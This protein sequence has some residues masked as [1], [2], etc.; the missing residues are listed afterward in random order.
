MKPRVALLATLDTKAEEAQYVAQRLADF[1]CEPVVFNLGTQDNPALPA[2]VSRDDLWDSAGIRGDSAT[3]GKLASMNRTV[4]GAT[5][6][7]NEMIRAQEIGAALAIGGG[8]GSWISSAIYRALPFGFPRLLV[9]TA[10]RDAGQ[11]SQFSDMFTVFSVT[12]IAGLNPILTKVLDNAAAAVAGLAMHSQAAPPLP[13]G[14]VAV[15]VYGI[16]SAGAKYVLSGLEAK[17]WRPV[18][19]HANGVGGP[20]LEAQVGAGG[21]EAVL[22]W[23]ITEV[24]DE[25]VGGICSAGPDRLKSA[26]RLGLPQVIVPGGIDVVNFAAPNTMPKK[27]QGRKV[28]AHTPDATL[29]RTN[30]AENRAIARVVAERLND[31]TGPVS[32]LIPMGGFSALSAEAGPL[33]DPAA[34][35]AFATELEAHLKPSIPVRRIDAA[36]NTPEFAAEAV[37]AFQEIAVPVPAGTHQTI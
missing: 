6:R 32:V 33:F 5:V 15:S 4:D 14:L 23:S 12:D 37:R 25:I 35:L 11:Y 36:I 2:D 8:Q 27:Y 17:S 13:A 1:G 34:D 9:S 18:S 22:D 31:A 30:P 26:G 24:A 21:F 19:F 7:I 10:G 28:H 16:T 20:T 29:M 3:G